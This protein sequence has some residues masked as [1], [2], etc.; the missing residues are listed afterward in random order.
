MST[1][2]GRYRFANSREKN[3]LTWYSGR[4]TSCTIFWGRN[5]TEPI[6]LKKSVLV[7]YQLVLRCQVEASTPNLILNFCSTHGRSVAS[8]YVLFQVSVSVFSRMHS[9]FRALMF[10]MNDR[11]RIRRVEGQ[12]PHLYR[13]YP[14]RQPVWLAAVRLDV[15]A[16]CTPQGT[17]WIL[18]ILAASLPS[19]QLSTNELTI[20]KCFAQASSRCVT[21]ITWPHGHAWFMKKK[22]AV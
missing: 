9:I 14:H 5:V 11:I 3:V 4:Q 16:F 1:E 6:V 19:Y 13:S 15:F 17:L 18:F 2:L 8:L 22:L 12:T 10:V 7:E 21:F 20:Q